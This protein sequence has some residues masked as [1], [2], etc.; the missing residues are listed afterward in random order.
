MGPDPIEGG[1]WGELR[2]PGMWIATRNVPL[3]I[4]ALGV[5]YSPPPIFGAL[6]QPFCISKCIMYCLYNASKYE[7]LLLTTVSTVKISLQISTEYRCSLNHEN[8]TCSSCIRTYCISL[9][10]LISVLFIHS[11]KLGVLNTC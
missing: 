1:E 4:S 11:D 3:S 6:S 5:L 9:K 10:V 7:S 2:G 8:L